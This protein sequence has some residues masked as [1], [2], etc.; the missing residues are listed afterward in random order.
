MTKAAELIA[1]AARAALA[2]GMPLDD[3]SNALE[4][5]MLRAAGAGTEASGVVARSCGITLD[6]LLFL[7]ANRQRGLRRER[8]PRRATMMRRRPPAA[9]VVD[10]AAWRAARA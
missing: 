8:E 5:E 9:P 1:L 2:E 3:A 6:Y 7:L 4:A 10:L